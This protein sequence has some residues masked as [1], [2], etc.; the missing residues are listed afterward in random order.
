MILLIPFSAGAQTEFKKNYKKDINLK[1]IEKKVN[2]KESVE[3]LLDD[4]ATKKADESRTNFDFD[5]M[6]IDGQ[7]KAPT[8]FL[9]TGKKNQ[10]LKRMIKLRKN[11]KEE[12][13]KSPSQ[14]PALVK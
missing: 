1:K 11:F 7:M 9:I 3:D 5:D 12:L 14:L 2:K 13:K 10:A 4:T 6:L 8:G